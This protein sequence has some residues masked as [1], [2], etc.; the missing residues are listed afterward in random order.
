MLLKQFKEKKLKKILWENEIH[1]LLCKLYKL[2]QSACL[3][4]NLKKNVKCSKQTST[5]WVYGKHDKA[6][7]RSI[8]LMKK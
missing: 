8:I 7:Y 2:L 3:T 4:E 6:A 5:I 1:N